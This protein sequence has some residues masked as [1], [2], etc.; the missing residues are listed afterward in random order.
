MGKRS[1]KQKVKQRELRNSGVFTE[2]K[3]Q[4]E[5]R[6]MSQYRRWWRVPPKCFVRWVNCDIRYKEQ[7]LQRDGEQFLPDSPV[8]WCMFRA[9]R[10]M[11][12]SAGI[13]LVEKSDHLS[14]CELVYEANG[15][16]FWVPE[17]LSRFIVSVADGR[18]ELP[19][20]F[21]FPV[22]TLSIAPLPF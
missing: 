4:D 7:L 16:K 5:Q 20:S 21:W 13:F 14:I 12:K 17:S 9:I 6:G 10:Q 19:F 3:R 11:E 2:A 18:P 1:K 8:F 22:P 15:I